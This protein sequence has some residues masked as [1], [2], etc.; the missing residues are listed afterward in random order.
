MLWRLK[1]K[2]LCR[3]C[4]RVEN[5]S[6]VYIFFVFIQFV[7]T[8]FIKIPCQRGEPYGL[9]EKAI[10]WGGIR[11]N[12]SHPARG[13]N[14][15]VRTRGGRAPPTPEL[16]HCY[17]IPPRRSRLGRDKFWHFF[18]DLINNILTKTEHKCVKYSL[19]FLIDLI[20]LSYQIGNPATCGE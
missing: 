11:M 5:R 1:T 14:R 15:M 8:R 9:V 4:F 2:N 20:I 18:K 17:L 10:F 6:G 13:M 7:T 3:V 16:T 12:A 19:A